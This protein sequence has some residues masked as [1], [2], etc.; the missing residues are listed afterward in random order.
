MNA[1]VTI[2]CALLLS[3]MSVA[4]GEEAPRVYLRLTR[5]A[6]KDQA[7]DVSIGFAG[8]AGSELS[9]VWY[10]RYGAPLAVVMTISAGEEA[11]VSLR[12][13]KDIATVRLPP[14]IF[15]LVSAQWDTATPFIVDGSRF[16]LV[17]SLK[18]LPPERPNKAPEPT[19]TSVT[20]PADAGA[21]PAAVVAHL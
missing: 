4:C 2:L 16:L 14:E 6:E 3:L 9:G 12:F 15:H 20:S 21:A 11:L 18:G 17:A 10:P 19:P 7:K 13:S 8:K 1:K 5:L